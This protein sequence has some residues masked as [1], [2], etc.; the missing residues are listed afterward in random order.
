MSEALS[1]RCSSTVS[2]WFYLTACSPCPAFSW[3]HSVV[4]AE[5]GLTLAHV[6]C[7]FSTFTSQS[8]DFCTLSVTSLSNFPDLLEDVSVSTV[9]L[10]RARPADVLGLAAPVSGGLRVS[11]GH[12]MNIKRMLTCLCLM[13]YFHHLQWHSCTAAS[14]RTRSQLGDVRTFVVTRFAVVSYG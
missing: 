4:F 2:R 1:A 11:S 10:A 8:G 14:P 9:A 5:S 12:D 7:R 3:F 13:R 6:Y